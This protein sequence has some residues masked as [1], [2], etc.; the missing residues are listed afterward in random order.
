M[1]VQVRLVTTLVCGLSIFGFRLY[2][3]IQ[4]LPVKSS[5]LAPMT[6]AGGHR[7]SLLVFQNA[8]VD[9]KDVLGDVRSSALSDS[10]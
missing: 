6:V 5:W 7:T 1:L 4:F 9:L 10:V 2:M 8:V 3:A